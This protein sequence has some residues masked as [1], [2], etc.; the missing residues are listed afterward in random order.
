MSH[1]DEVENRTCLLSKQNDLLSHNPLMTQKDDKLLYKAYFLEFDHIGK[2]TNYMETTMQLLRSYIYNIILFIIY[3]HFIFIMYSNI[4][5][6]FKS[7]AI[8]NNSQ[9]CC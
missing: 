9:K 8:H 4:N 7:H 3:V 1:R 6:L 2:L 5:I